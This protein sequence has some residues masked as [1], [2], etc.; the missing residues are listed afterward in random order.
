MMMH[1]RDNP[2]L[3][4]D[5][6][7]VVVVMAYHAKDIQ[8]SHWRSP[9]TNEQVKVNCFWEKYKIFIAY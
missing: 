9:S 3:R 6:S 8:V 4:S 5:S 2:W 1:F 7:D